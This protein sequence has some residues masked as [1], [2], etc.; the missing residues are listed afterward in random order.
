LDS[1]FRLIRMRIARRR[2]CP[3]T[4]LARGVCT[5][6]RGKAGRLVAVA[7]LGVLASVGLQGGP[8][9]AEES[10]PSLVS[11]EADQSEI[12]VPGSTQV[13][14]VAD[15]SLY[16]TGY[17]IHIV[18]DDGESGE[19]VCGNSDS[20]AKTVLAAWSDSVIPRPRR[21]HAEIRHIS[22]GEVVSRSEQVTVQIRPHDFQL[23]I[24][25]DSPSI[26]VPSSTAVRATVDQSLYNTG[27]AIHIVDDDRE[28]GDSVCGNSNDCAKT[29]LAA[30]SDSVIPRPRHFHAE[31]RHISSGELLARSEQVT[32]QIQP[33]DFQLR[34]SAD[35]ASITVPNSTA[36]R[37]T[38]D[39]SLYN[40]GY[41]IHIVDDDG[42]TSNSV[43]G[44][45][46]D[47]AK[48]VFAA[49]SD[50]A[51][52]RTRDFHAEVRHNS[53]GQVV[54]RSG[55][56]GV[57]IEPYDFDLTIEPDS[58]SITVPNSTRVTATVNRS[59][60][61]TGYQI[62]IV[63]DD[64]ETGEAVCG[65]GDSCAKTVWA[66]WS[67]NRN[68]TARQFHAEVRSF[69]TGHVAAVSDPVTV[70]RRRFVFHPTVSFWTRTDTNGNVIQMA[71]ART[72][73]AD[74]SL[75]GTGHQ[76]K[77]ISADGSVLCSAP[78]I[79]CDAAA[80]IGGTYRAVVVEAGGHNVGD[81]GAWTLT[82]EGASERTADGLDLAYLAA[83][84]GGPSELCNRVLVSPY[85]T[86]FNGSTLSDQYIACDAGL[87]AGLST[88]ETLERI[89]V[90]GGSAAA[91]LAA[92]HWL[93]ADATRP[94]PAPEQVTPEDG[95]APLPVPLPL[96]RQVQDLSDRLM[97]GQPRL[98]QERADIVANQCLLLVGRLGVNAEKKCSTLPIFATGV[99]DVPEATNHDR[100]AISRVP[101]WVLLNRES[102]AGKPGEGWATGRCDP[103]AGLEQDCDEYP[104]FSTFQGG[105]AA[106]PEPHLEA[107]SRHDNR[108]QGNKLQHFYGVNGCNVPPPDP[109]LVIPLPRASGLP[110]LEV[111]N[112]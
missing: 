41:A 94:L 64:G 98:T 29:V 47:C 103:P 58:P 57:A 102:T 1:L 65:N 112:P 78:Q 38:V 45:S 13:W 42:E 55:Q 17:R 37:A 10:P 101:A 97:E 89:V 40:T 15:R 12:T 9:V 39:Q 34:I 52:P 56:V 106:I 18:D 43:C 44:N 5:I 95:E 74:P 21:F 67:V 54:A 48:T 19:I 35:S 32:V 69:M 76:I 59:L 66:P 96:V 28:S 85:T 68:P 63:D 83:L 91:G 107:I 80:A 75:Y 14:A 86:H 79:G 16:N 110:T 62:H 24:S 105:P 111:C 33:H 61:N 92:L 25:A 72:G 27:Y 23:Q 31:V 20:C 93:Q 22:T 84:V 87:R 26:T 70:V 109:F 82:S 3:T 60:Y 51:N 99:S 7:G 77:L 36:V 8:A 46:N 108:S 104:F 11:F 53:S 88:I 49:W 4:L 6:W 100:K 2:P 71:A 50:N 30:W 81:S 73:S 90:A